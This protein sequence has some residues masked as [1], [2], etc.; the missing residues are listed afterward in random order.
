MSEASAQSQLP[1]LSLYVH[2][3]WCVR[4][5]P[6][7]DFNSHQVAAGANSHQVA[8]S[9]HEAAGPNSSGYGLPEVEY[10]AQLRRDLHSQL[11]W[12][13]GRKL[14]SIFFGGGTP[15]LFSPAAIGAILEL[16]EKSVGFEPDIEIT[17]E[18]NPGT[19]EQ[20]KFSGYRAA[21]VNRLSIGVQSF[22]PRQLVNLGR[23]HSGDEA[24]GAVD[25]ARRA[26]FDNINLDLMHG[27]PEQTEEEALTDLRRAVSLEPEHISWY[28]LT[29]E[30]NTAFYSAPPVTPGSA[31]IASMQGTGR[32]YLAS[33]GYPRYEVSAYARTG[34]ESRHNLNYWAF[35]DY[36]GI[37]AGA[38]G[39]VTLPDEGRILRSRR[40][41][42]PRH[43]LAAAAA[44][45]GSVGLIHSE[46]APPHCDDIEREDLPLEFLMNAL[47]L[48]AGVPVQL[49]SRHTGLPLAALEKNWPALQA[50]ELVQPLERRI[51]ASAFGFDYL[52][53]ILQRFLEQP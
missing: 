52:D 9:S 50:M 34:L 15:S 27:L 32:D 4:K 38:H 3:P 17:L 45:Q 11:P 26:G 25:M 23:I 8:A 36:L 42:A 18:A 7:C 48:V 1:P 44:E 51:A 5:C 16:A 10:V 53:E 14:R 35:G 41:R 2:I 24:I 13:Q 43:Y 21:G 31:L 33:Q 40:T 29:I 28:Q 22:E 37:G 30:P 49:F 47:R 12:A 6:Y 20:E 39:K 19:F 46:M